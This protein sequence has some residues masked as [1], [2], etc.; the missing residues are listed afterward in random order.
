MS[1][2]EL[3]ETLKATQKQLVKA[4]QDEY[5]CDDVEPPPEAFGWGEQALRDYMES[6]GSGTGAAAITAAVALH[7]AFVSACTYSH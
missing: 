7:C 1:V 6:G 2:A 4:L 5:F 3:V